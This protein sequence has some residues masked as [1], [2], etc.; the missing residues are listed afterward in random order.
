M[1]TRCH[2]C[3]NDT[4]EARSSFK[5]DR[6]SH[7][8]DVLIDGSCRRRL[9]KDSWGERGLARLRRINAQERFCLLTR[10]GFFVKDKVTMAGALRR[11]AIERPVIFWSFVI[12]SIGSWKEKK[13]LCER[14]RWLTRDRIDNVC[15]PNHGLDCPND[16]SSILWLQG[17][18]TTSYY[19][20]SY[21][22]IVEMKGWRV[23]IHNETCSS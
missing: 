14:T 23:S 21:V 2:R 7:W 13:S 19:L 15:R 3:S 17:R 8:T 12:G 6:D 10:L 18:W 9:I 5:S 11:F 20:P 22:M 1:L 16:P 4:L